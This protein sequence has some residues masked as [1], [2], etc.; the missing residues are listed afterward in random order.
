[1]GSAAASEM[2]PGSPATEGEVVDLLFEVCGATLPADYRHALRDAILH[3]LPWLEDEPAAAIHPLKSARGDDGTLLLA[4]RTRL[5]LRVPASRH[6]DASELSGRALEMR[7]SRITCG[8]ST[9]R[10]LLAHGT[11]YAHLVSGDIDDEPGFMAGMR[12]ELETLG[13]RGEIICGRRQTIGEGDRRLRGFSVMAHG[14]APEASLLLQSRG[15]GSD[16]KLGCGIFVPHRSAAP[17][18]G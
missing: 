9:K 8:Q 11:V 7:T 15:T 16:M 4:A 17:V 1:M 3:E 5:V 13:I 2:I 12:A 10:A 18:G 6:A 14:L